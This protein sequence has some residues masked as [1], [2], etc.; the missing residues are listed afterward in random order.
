MVPSFLLNR[1]KSK[2][3]AGRA[4]K[5]NKLVNAYLLVGLNGVVLGEEGVLSQWVPFRDGTVPLWD[6]VR[7]IIGSVQLVFF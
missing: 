5:E 7:V 2:A 4:K 6:F 3:C 1:V